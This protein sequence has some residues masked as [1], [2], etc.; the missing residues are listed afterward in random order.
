MNT[1]TINCSGIVKPDTNLGDIITA[2]KEVLYAHH[3]AL[4]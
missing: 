3:I 4:E 2:I 1:L